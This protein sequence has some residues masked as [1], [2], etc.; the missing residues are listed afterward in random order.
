M[1]L[2]REVTG[3]NV[4]AA[5]DLVDSFVQ[6]NVSFTFRLALKELIRKC[7]EGIFGVNAM[8]M[9]LVCTLSQLV[10]VCSRLYAVIC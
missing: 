3:K 9:L 5:F 7:Y 4:V 10:P 6:L 2:F 8:Q 1:L